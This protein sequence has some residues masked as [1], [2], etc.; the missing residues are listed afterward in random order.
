MTDS[1]T[2]KLLQTDGVSDL[3]IAEHGSFGDEIFIELLSIG[4]GADGKGDLNTGDSL[5]ENPTINPLHSKFSKGLFN[6]KW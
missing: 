5:A 4:S 6:W 1:Q 2:R 3:L